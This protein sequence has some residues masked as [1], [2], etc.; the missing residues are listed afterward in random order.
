MLNPK[1]QDALND[2]INAEVFSSYLYLSMAAYFES[3]G[4]SGMAQWMR[5]QTQEENLHATKFFDY[6]CERDGRVTLKAIDAPKVEWT[7][8]LDAFEESYQHEQMITG[9]INKLVAV[10]RQENDPATESFLQWFVN[11][12]VEE[13]SSVRTILDQLKL[14]G[15]NGVA[16]YMIDGQLAQRAPAAAAA[17]SGAGA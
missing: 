5:V 15:D 4:M 6:I 3:Q 2:Q 11:E 13:E 16:L 7:S 17:S 8:A 1:V 12:Q 14:V 9:R 10:A